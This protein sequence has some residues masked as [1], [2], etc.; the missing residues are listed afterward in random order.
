M[1]LLKKG[2]TNT[3]YWIL[4]RILDFIQAVNVCLSFYFCV[5]A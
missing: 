4:L 5:S 1:I 2:K 3:F